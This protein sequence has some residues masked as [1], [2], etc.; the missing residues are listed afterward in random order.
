VLRRQ[1][2]EEEGKE[3][4]SVLSALEKWGGRVLV[5]RGEGSKGV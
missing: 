3:L 5:H 2:G 4:E 1:S